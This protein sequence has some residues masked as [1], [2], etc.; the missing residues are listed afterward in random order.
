MLGFHS[1]DELL[2]SVAAAF[3]CGFLI[4]AGYLL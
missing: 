3:L 1:L 4:V 2:F